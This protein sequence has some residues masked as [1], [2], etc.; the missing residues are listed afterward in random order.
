MKQKLY[1][2]AKWLTT[3]F[4]ISLAVVTVLMLVLRL[5]VFRDMASVPE[6]EVETITDDYLT[7]TINRQVYFAK[8]TSKGNL[9][10]Q[11]LSQNDY[12]MSV[13]IIDPDTEISYIYTGFIEPGAGRD[14]VTL[15]SELED[16]VYSFVAVVSAY[17]MDSRELLLTDKLDITLHIGQAPQT[18]G[19][20]RK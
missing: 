11:N 13:D 7:Y 15:N 6:T 2:N 17:D 3:T 20:S 1:G 18:N 5:S 4:C 12:Y 16:G 8:S 9:M 10:I 19:A 14:T